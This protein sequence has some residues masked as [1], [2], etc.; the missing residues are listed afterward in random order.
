LTADRDEISHVVEDGD[1]SFVAV[2]LVDSNGNLVSHSQ[3]NITYS[4]EGA[5]TLLA[6]GSGNPATDEG[7]IGNERCLFY[8]KGMIAIR[9]NTD[10][11]AGDTVTVCA[12]NEDGITG[13]CVIRL[14]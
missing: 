2:E 14:K 7:Y 11:N 1:I 8:G 3:E 10:A 9:P 4:V 6:V 12:K 5:G 13:K